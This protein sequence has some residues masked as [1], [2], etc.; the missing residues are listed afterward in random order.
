M[1]IC[2]HWGVELFDDWLI[3]QIQ[4]RICRMT[5]RLSQGIPWFGGPPSR[6]TP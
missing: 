4:P 6:E 5:S 3:H 1:R 2:R